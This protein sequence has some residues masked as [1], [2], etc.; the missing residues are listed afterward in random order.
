LASYPKPPAE[1]LDA[2]EAQRAAAVGN[3]VQLAEIDATEAGL[4][5]EYSI[6]GRIGHA[7]EPAIRPLGY[8]WRIG[9]GLIA[10]FAAREVFV[11]AMST[12]YAV[13]EVEDDTSPL[14]DQL[15]SATWDSGSL[16]GQ[17]VFTLPVAV[18]LL[19]F[20]VFALQCVSTVAIMWRETNGW[21]WP[22]FAWTY[23]LGLAYVGAWIAKVLT[24][25]IV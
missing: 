16:K 4:V 15:K 14:A 10:S 24:E 19:I 18:S 11:S 2:L 12:I 6:A 7:I 5:V 8:D 23:M 3:D 25:M 17:T 1:R 9:V 21:K 22:L 20:Y 13:G